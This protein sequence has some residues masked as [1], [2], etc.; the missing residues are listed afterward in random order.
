MRQR[1]VFALV[2]VSMVFILS[3][4]TK[5]GNGSQGANRNYS[6]TYNG[7]YNSATINIFEYDGNGDPIYH[8]G[9]KFY[10]GKTKEYTAQSSTTK[11]KIHVEL[12]FDIGWVPTAYSISNSPINVVIDDNTRLGGEPY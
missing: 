4:C 9:G 7:H 2:A 8:V 3:S 10:Q 12:P 5:E 1:L 11:I 6:V